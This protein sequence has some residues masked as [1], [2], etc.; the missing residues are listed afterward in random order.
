MW[1]HL[2]SIGTIS[3]VTDENIENI[4]MFLGIPNQ[5][6]KTIRYWKQDMAKQRHCSE[7]NRFKDL[8]EKHVRSKRS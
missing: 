2:N 7:R 1:K 5:Y 6:W 3:M 8:T 4:K